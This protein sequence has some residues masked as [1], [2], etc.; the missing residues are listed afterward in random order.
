M[1]LFSQL[2]LHTYKIRDAFNDKDGPYTREFRSK[3]IDWF[4]LDNTDELLHKIKG[5][6]LVSIDQTPLTRDETRKVVDQYLGKP[7]YVNSII[8]G[9]FIN[10]S[11]GSKLVK[12]LYLEQMLVHPGIFFNMLYSGF[13]ELVFSRYYRY[14]AKDNHFQLPWSPTIYFEP[15]ECKMGCN[16][17]FGIT[18]Y[19]KW[20]RYPIISMT[21]FNHFYA[22][23]FRFF[24]L[25]NSIVA[26][27][28]LPL[29]FYLFSKAKNKIARIEA[30]SFF[31][32]SMLYW[33]P[34]IA[35]MFL[36]LIIFRYQA[37][38]CLLLLIM[39]ALVVMRSYSLFFSRPRMLSDMPG[40]D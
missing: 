19:I 13:S 25:I 7:T 20:R 2:Y 27:A 5:T 24:I 31:A 29:Y 10:T 8:Y 1:Q 33:L 36:V 30:L 38:S 28:G 39:S 17:I 18:K 34:N 3:M 11:N 6:T 37:T 23:F 4:M 26:I 35:M 9:F 32:L 16:K 40:S 12:N 21:G 15:F 14:S 22:K